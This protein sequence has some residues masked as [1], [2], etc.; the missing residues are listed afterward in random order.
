VKCTNSYISAIYGK[1]STLVDRFGVKCGADFQDA[2]SYGGNGGTNVVLRTCTGGYSSVKVTFDKYVGSISAFCKTSYAFQRIGLGVHKDASA[3]VGELEC[4][5]NQILTGVDINSGAYVDRVTFFCGG[6][7][8][9][10]FE[11]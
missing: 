4:N 10:V 7:L 6:S 8:S 1:A 3:I 11:D 5:N 2:G 9:Y